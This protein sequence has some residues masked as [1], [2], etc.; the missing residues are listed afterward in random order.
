MDP[1]NQ[2]VKQK[3]LEVSNAIRKK[4]QALKHGKLQSDVM[5]EA[6]YKPIVEPL[7]ELV[8]QKRQ[9][10]PEPHIVPKKRKLSSLPVPATP[11]TPL[12]SHVTS[13]PSPQ[14]PTV[15]DTDEEE[16][17]EEEEEETPTG[18]S[19]DDVNQSPKRYVFL[20]K[21]NQKT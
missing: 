13:T 11:I 20:S 8:D 4:F 3:L 21:F 2:E 7:K 15:D 18:Y 10:P 1:Q 5:L 17:E 16:E 9:A 19:L 12:S 14:Y 6:A